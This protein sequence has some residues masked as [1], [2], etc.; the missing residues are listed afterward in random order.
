[1]FS[2]QAI[3]QMDEQDENDYRTLTVLL[4]TRS[5]HTC[6]HLMTRKWDASQLKPNYHCNTLL[7]T[8][9]VTVN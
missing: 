6:L 9:S 4:L 7:I 5:L 1:M 8:N 2:T 3:K